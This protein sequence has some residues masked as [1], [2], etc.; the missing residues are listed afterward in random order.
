MVAPLWLC[1]PYAS[2]GACASL[3]RSEGHH[4]FHLLSVDA[5][6]SV[7]YSL[8]RV[9]SGSVV[10]FLCLI[11]LFCAYPPLSL[12]LSCLH[13]LHC[14]IIG[15]RLSTMERLLLGGRLLHTTLLCW[16]SRTSCVLV[17]LLQLPRRQQLSIRAYF[18]RLHRSCLSWYTFYSACTG[19]NVHR[20]TPVF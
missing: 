15:G 12:G 16:C 1:A 4:T 11:T 13:S 3:F 7:L 5:I 18:L 20:S 14:R 8:Y 2:I 19:R 10:I 9:H 17:Q 6:C